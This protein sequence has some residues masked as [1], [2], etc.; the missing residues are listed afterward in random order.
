[1]FYYHQMFKKH[2]NDV[3]KTRG[4]GWEIKMKDINIPFFFLMKL[5]VVVLLFNSFRSY[6]ARL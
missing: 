5:F 6:N 4:D 1:M 3:L 2:N